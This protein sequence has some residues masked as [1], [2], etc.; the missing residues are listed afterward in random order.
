MMGSI[1]QAEPNGRQQTEVD[2]IHP[3]RSSV[4]THHHFILKMTRSGSLAMS[5]YRYFMSA[6]LS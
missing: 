4:L 2:T 6:G 1:F 3:A 5:V